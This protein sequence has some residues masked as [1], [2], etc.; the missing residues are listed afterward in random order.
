MLQTA[1]SVR[2]SWKSCPP[3]EPGAVLTRAARLMRD[4]IDEYARLLTMK[5]GKTLAG[6]R[7]EWNRAV[8]TFA[9]HGRQVEQLNAMTKL[10]TSRGEQSIL[11]EPIG[12]VVAF[13]PWNYPV[14]NIA[15]KLAAALIAGC[16]VILKQ[17]KT[18]P[19]RQLQLRVPC[20]MLGCRGKCCNCCLGSLLRSRALLVS[21]IVRLVSFTGSTPLGRLLARLAADRLIRLVPELGGHSQLRSV[22]MLISENFSLSLD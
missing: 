16:P 9:W 8:E 5:Q 7:V 10:Q 11:P 19:L 18:P 3:S 21:P 1:D 6:S 12:V 22:L 2:H 14:V 17:Q 4:R 13:T 15:R 20:L